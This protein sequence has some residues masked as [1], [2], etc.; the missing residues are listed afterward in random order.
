M[1]FY[2]H[3]KFNNYYIV[4]DA[5]DLHSYDGVRKKTNYSAI[6][7]AVMDYVDFSYWYQLLYL[8]QLNLIYKSITSMLILA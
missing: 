4:Y 8:V 6:I 2:N 3:V 7:P 5:Q 1:S